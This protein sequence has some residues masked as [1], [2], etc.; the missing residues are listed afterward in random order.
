MRLS[1]P[2]KVKL[3]RQHLTPHEL[4]T[5]ESY[6]RPQN[7]YQYR[8]PRKERTPIFDSEW[9]QNRKAKKKLKV[10]KR[11][12]IAKIKSQERKDEAA[13]KTNVGRP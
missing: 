5:Y 3:A 1:H 6:G 13:K 2:Q 7:R 9:W 8:H 4:I 10:A 11:E 12:E